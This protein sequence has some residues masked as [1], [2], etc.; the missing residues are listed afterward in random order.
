LRRNS[1]AQWT[2]AFG[3]CI[4]GILRRDGG[5]RTNLRLGQRYWP[6]QRS[7]SGAKADQQEVFATSD[8]TTIDTRE[9]GRTGGTP[10]LDGTTASKTVD[11][12][13]LQ[14]HRAPQ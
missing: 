11:E 10:E 5:K 3:L 13:E 1:A 14:P 4:T 9:E 2:V 7:G 12:S 8:V 6:D